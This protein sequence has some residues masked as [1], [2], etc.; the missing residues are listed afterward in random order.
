[1]LTGKGMTEI[2]KTIISGGVIITLLIIV[3][4]IAPLISPSEPLAQNLSASLSSPG[5]SAF[6]G[7]DSLG[8]DIFSR[9]VYGSRISLTVGITVLTLT[10][11]LGTF[12]GMLAGY[13]GGV[14]DSVLMRVSDVFMSFP[15]LVLAMIVMAFIGPGIANLVGVLVII[16]WPQFARLVRGQV[17]SVKGMAYV[18]AARIA[19]TH[20]LKIVLKHILPNCFAPVITYG[21]MS[22]GAIIIDETALSFLGLGI[23]PPAPSWGVMLADAKNYIAAAPWL[24]IFPG[25]AMI[26]TVLGFNL[27]GDGLGYLLNPKQRERIE[28]THGNIKG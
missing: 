23:Q 28:V 7:T 1:M 9:V 27:L 16:R 2:N 12:L 20:P 15:P 11:F 8:R 4:I 26:V 14:L 24:V 5:G 25:L 21:T 13:F 6:F 22:L 19:G 10:L 3:A 17:I 18:D